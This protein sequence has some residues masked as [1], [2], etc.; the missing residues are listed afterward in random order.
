MKEEVNNPEHYNK[1]FIEAIDII[2]LIVDNDAFCMGNF[3]KYIIRAPYK[4]NF[5]K[6]I[7]KAHWYLQ[8][9]L[10]HVNVK[11]FSNF[12]LSTITKYLKAL[13]NSTIEEKKCVKMLGIILLNYN[14]RINIPDLE[15]KFL[16]I[17]GDEIYDEQSDLFK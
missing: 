2:G 4:G 16:R 10:D 9:I 14:S 1:S 17:F 15:E 5:K 12:E 13:D 7:K 11:D 3:L 6:D 8:N